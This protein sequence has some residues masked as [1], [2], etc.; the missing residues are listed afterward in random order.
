MKNLFIGIDFSK[1]KIDA[2]VISAI[3]LHRE[4]EVLPGR[5]QKLLSHENWQLQCWRCGEIRKWHTIRISKSTAR[6]LSPLKK[7]S[8]CTDK[9]KNKDKKINKRRF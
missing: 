7:Y 8:L 2:T 4:E 9:I 5:K 1:E 3:G 6:K